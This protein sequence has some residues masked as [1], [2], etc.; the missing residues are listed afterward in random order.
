[1]KKRRRS[2]FQELDK[3]FRALGLYQQ[4]QAERTYY[5]GQAEFQETQNDNENLAKELLPILKKYLDEDLIEQLEDKEVNNPFKNWF[6]PPPNYM[7]HWNNWLKNANKFYAPHLNPFTGFNPFT[8]ETEELDDLISEL[9]Y[10]IRRR[11][12]KTE[13]KGGT[14]TEKEIDPIIDEFKAD[15]IDYLKEEEEEEASN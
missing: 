13:A 11:Q 12:R 2:S 8:G 9:A 4:Q 7:D 6:A 14:M 10:N 3:L 1:M 5:G 15:L